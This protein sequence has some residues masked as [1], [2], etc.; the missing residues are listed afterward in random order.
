MK[1]CI[2]VAVN[3]G[4]WLG[5]SLGEKFGMTAAFLASGVGSVLGVFLGWRFAR[6]HLG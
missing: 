1:L 6:A 5:W 3:V 2:F 4:G